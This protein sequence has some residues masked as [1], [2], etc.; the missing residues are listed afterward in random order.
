MLGTELEIPMCLENK[1][2]LYPTR[3]PN[4]QCPLFSVYG[5]DIAGA[6]HLVNVVFCFFEFLIKSNEQ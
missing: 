5:G 3:R 1:L 6:P 4:A 2:A